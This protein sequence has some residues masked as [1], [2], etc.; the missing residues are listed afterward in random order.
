MAKLTGAKV[1]SCISKLVGVLPP[2]DVCKLWG[3]AMPRAWEG[4][5]VNAVLAFLRLCSPW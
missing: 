3:Q 4:Y 5:P 1:R 2:L